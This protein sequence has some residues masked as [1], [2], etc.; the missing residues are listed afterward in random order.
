MGWFLLSKIGALRDQQPEPLSRFRM[1]CS[2]LM[3]LHQ[4]INTSNHN[5]VL[6]IGINYARHRHTSQ[7]VVKFHRAL[8]GLYIY[9]IYIYMYGSNILIYIPY[10]Y[11][12]YYI[13]HTCMDTCIDTIHMY[14]YIYTIPP[15]TIHMCR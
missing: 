4:L 10:M 6:M 3:F 8:Y 1:F 15:R 5:H 12:Y 9:V 13:Y 7:S 14:N 2:R 11:R